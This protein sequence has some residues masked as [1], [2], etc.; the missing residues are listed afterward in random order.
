MIAGGEGITAEMNRKIKKIG[1]N[2]D[3]R[4]SCEMDIMGIN[5]KNQHVKTCG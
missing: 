2:N 3:K 4:N 1:A 5:Q